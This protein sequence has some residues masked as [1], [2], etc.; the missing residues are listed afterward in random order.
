MIL[1]LLCKTDHSKHTVYE[2]LKRDMSIEV[3]V[4]RLLGSSGLFSDSNICLLKRLK[5]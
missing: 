3:M 5:P 4:A 2:I 1:N